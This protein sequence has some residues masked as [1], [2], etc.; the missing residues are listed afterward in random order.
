MVWHYGGDVNMI[1][2]KQLFDRS[3]NRLDGS[4]L[5]NSARKKIEKI[6]GDYAEFYTKEVWYEYVINDENKKVDFIFRITERKKLTRFV[7]NML[8]RADGENKK[9]WDLILA[10]S[11]EW[12]DNIY[13]QKYVRSMSFEFD[14][15]Q[16]NSNCVI[17]SIFL[18]IDTDS[19]EDE[20]KIS[21]YSKVMPVIVNK[22]STSKNKQMLLQQIEKVYNEND[23]IIAMWQI[24]LMYS[25]NDD[26]IRIFTNIIETEKAEKFIYNYCCKQAKKVSLRLNKM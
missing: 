22:L 17:P 11:E 21:I 3:E 23:G 24:G 2:V 6:A 26:G 13:L 1:K 5:N 15:E 16:I 25:R 12:N 7:K 4:I 10:F 14:Y 8:Q 20:D 18:E 9:I 19:F